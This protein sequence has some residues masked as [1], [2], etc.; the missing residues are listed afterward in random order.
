MAV[1]TAEQAD[2]LDLVHFYLLVSQTHHFGLWSGIMMKNLGNVSS[3]IE[4][5]V[6]GTK[7]EKNFPRT[8]PSDFTRSPD[9]A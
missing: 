1:R 2:A 8:F 5:K 4:W 7:T 3:E 6:I 9:L